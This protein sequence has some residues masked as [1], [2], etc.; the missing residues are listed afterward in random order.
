MDVMTAANIFPARNELTETDQFIVF[1]GERLATRQTK[2]LWNLSEINHLLGGDDKLIFIDVSA[3]GSYYLL[4]VDEDPAGSLGADLQSLRSL[5]FSQSELAFTLAGKAAQLID[6]YGSHRFC[7]ACGTETSNHP[8]Q[9]AVICHS[10]KKHY[11][12]RINPCAIMLIVDGDKI[13]LA[14]SARFKSNFFSCLAGFMEVGE[15]AEETVAREVREEVG[16]EIENI[17][18]LK[19][20]SW[21]FPSQLMLGFIADYKSG[22]IVPEPGEIEEANWYHVDELPVVPSPGIS[23]AGELIQYYVQQVRGQS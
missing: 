3:E 21:P 16:L 20:Q 14:R 23:V 11:F 13:L 22:D 17:R 7:G 8:E 5:L 6:W 19:S 12:P 1:F 9:R 4:Q 2:F 10:C 18:Y 15:T